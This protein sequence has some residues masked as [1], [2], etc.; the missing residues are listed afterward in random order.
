MFYGKG[1]GKNY[2]PRTGSM[3][4]SPQIL[5]GDLEAEV[6]FNDD[7]AY[8]GG[9]GISTTEIFQAAN[10]G[11]LAGQGGWYERFRA[12]TERN[13]HDAFARAFG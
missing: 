13:V 12:E 1:P 5:M 10:A 6:Y 2:N 11:A 3:H 8:L 9:Q 7:Y 4:E